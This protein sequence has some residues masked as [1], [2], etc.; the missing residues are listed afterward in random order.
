MASATPQWTSRYAFLM[1]AI[2]SAVGL[3][4]LWRFPFHTGQN[5]GAAFVIVY[6]FC[7]AFI[8]YPI[9]MGEFS[10]GR[11]K[12]LSAVGS[13]RQLALDSGKSRHWSIV[14][15]VGLLGAFAIL[16]TYSIIAG[17]VIAYS[18]M[19]FAGE[20]AGT[21]VTDATQIAPLY[22]G[23]GYALFWHTLFMAATVLIVSRG[24]HGGIERVV[25]IAMPM[26]FVMLLGLC[27]YALV[28]GAAAKALDYLFRPD[29]SA[30]TPAVVLAAMGQAFFSVGIGGALMVTYGSFLSKD[31]NI[32]NS[33]AII[34]G[35]DTL[36]AV[37]AG[38]M[39]FPIVFA[40]GLDPAAGA[41]LIF[42][43]LPAV[44]ADMPGG[45]IIGGLFFFLAFIAALTTS[46][47]ILIAL[48]VAGEE[49]FGLGK[50]TSAFVFG[51]LTWAAGGVAVV[52]SDL[53]V[54]IDFL[55]GSV[56]LPLGGL[57]VAV[58]VGWV[59]PR[60]VMRKELHNTREVLFRLWHF[61]IR[62]V[63]PVAVALTLLLG[64][65]TKFDFGLNT[66]IAG[67]TAGE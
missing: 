56:F 43:A 45:N 10:V 8:A 67:L 3:G 44:F 48:S 21:A 61:F 66:L 24:L 39:I 51:A 42:D 37:V 58:F 60:S 31:E 64:I 6:L 11:H 7:V 65:D 47:A 19:S 49:Q 41:Q 40:H 46:I 52:V 13:V 2:G 38:L 16:T 55:S 23:A 30:I 17:Q 35:S 62:Y 1:A 27:V 54:W 32:G 25:T 14:G 26:F 50:K 18:V 4:N 20:F 5:G 33:A 29:F 59:A 53:A 15:W 63:G 34:A 36:V 12:G 28:T 22:A 57:L 9:L